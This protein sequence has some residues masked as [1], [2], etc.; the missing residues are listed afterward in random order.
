MPR[1]TFDITD[2]IHAKLSLIP[3]GSR[4]RVMVMIVENIARMI[5]ED[6]VATLAKLIHSTLELD[7]ITHTGKA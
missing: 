6:R 5:E 4:K 7:E 1:L 2:E 3:Y